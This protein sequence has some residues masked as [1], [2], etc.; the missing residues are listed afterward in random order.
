M[1]WQTK[2]KAEPLPDRFTY[3][4]RFLFAGSCFA[5][6]VA[7]RMR[8]LY[9]LVAPDAFGPLF[10]PASI[11]SSLERLESRVPFVSADVMHFPYGA[12]GSLS[13]HTSFSRGDEDV[14][15]EYANEQLK[16]ASDFFEKT[17]V[18]IV[19]LGTAWAYTYQ[20]KVVA[21]CHKMPARLFK[22]VF[23]EPEQIAVLMTPLLE[24]H[25]NKT[26]IM[27]VSPIRHWGDEAH[28]NQLSKSSL[29]L[30][31][32]RLQ[33]SFDN[34]VYFPSY[35]IVLDEL[36]DYRY[37]ADDQFHLAPQT[38]DYILKRFFEIAFN[39]ETI[40]LI[41]Q[42]QKLNASY[43]HRPLFP[44]SDEYTI[45]R[46]KLDKLRA[47]LLQTIGTQRKLC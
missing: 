2:V 22:R 23:M 4:T 7:Q 36:R 39:H 28:G 27:T 32:E 38:I 20:G 41:R 26:W 10:N 14:F 18:I 37:Y 24:R 25:R 46:K 3:A 21:N 8:E 40:G 42:M 5:T 19:T 1:E 13:H 44:L 29:L 45:F 16:A 17:N 35:E 12:Y 15:L 30:A 34:M 6:E 11:V 31:I 33:R 9:F 43:K 47:E